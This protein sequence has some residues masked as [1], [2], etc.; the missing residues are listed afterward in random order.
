M[1]NL[2]ISLPGNLPLSLPGNLPPSLRGNLPLSPTGNLPPSPM[3]NPPISP[4]IR[5]Q[6]LTP[7]SATRRIDVGKTRARRRQDSDFPAIP[8]A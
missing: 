5:R 6:T 1:G 7:Q 8:T 4:P 3:S 2:P